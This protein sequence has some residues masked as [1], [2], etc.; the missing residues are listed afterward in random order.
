MNVRL[1][2]HPDSFP[3]LGNTFVTGWGRVRTTVLWSEFAKGAQTS[4]ERK[5]LT[6]EMRARSIIDEDLPEVLVGSLTT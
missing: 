3:R 5:E 1:L 4:Q 6:F 2:V